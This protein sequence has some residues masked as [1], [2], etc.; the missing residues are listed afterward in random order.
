M[1]KQKLEIDC[2][3]C[4]A[5]LSIEARSCP[6]CGAD[7]GMADF[8]DLEN[9]ANDISGGTA[10]CK[11][12]TRPVEKKERDPV[13]GTSVNAVVDSPKVEPKQEMVESKPENEPSTP[14][15]EQEKKEDVEGSEPGK[16]K[17]LFSKFFSKKK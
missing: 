5:K 3:V 13:P 8:Q 6:K 15:L 10:S 12:P 7:L 17:G 1:P 4:D 16:K 9:L 2:P 11:E 14:K